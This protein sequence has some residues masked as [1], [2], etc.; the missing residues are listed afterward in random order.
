[1]AD[2]KAVITILGEDKASGPIGKANKSLGELDKTAT[3][4]GKALG[5]VQTA[6]LGVAGVAAGAVVA[7]FGASVKA[8]ADFESQISALKAVTGASAEDA[9]QLSDLAL[10]LG[11]DTAFS[12]S[13]AAAGL[14]ELAKGGVDV[15]DIMGGAA[16]ASL[17]LAA[18]GGIEVAEA[19][20]LAANAMALFNIQ[21]SEMGAVVDSIAGF[22]NATTGSVNDF[23]LAL[24]AVGAVADLS[25]QDFD[26]TATAIA[27]MGKA[28]IL[29]SDAGTSLKGVLLN[30]IPTTNAAQQAMVELGLAN[31]ETRSTFVDS[32]GNFKDLRDIAEELNRATKDLTES[33][34][35]LAL[36]VIFGSDA[37]RAAAILA[38]AGAEGFDAM[39]ES[40]SKVSAE[41]VAAERLNNVNGSMQAMQGSLETL[42]IT[43]G[44]EFLPMLK[45]L[46]D[47][48]TKLAN[49]QLIPFIQEHGP[50]W[51]ATVK[52]MGN[53][54][55]RFIDDP[56][57]GL[58]ETLPETTRLL[59]AMG[60]SGMGPLLTKTGELIVGL[61]KL[62][63]SD[64][65]GTIHLGN[66]FLNLLGPIG[67]AI[68][69]LEGASKSVNDVTAALSRFG[70]IANETFTAAQLIGSQMVEGVAAG[71]AGAVGKVADQARNMV[72]TAM[73]AAR[74]KAEAKSPSEWFARDVGEPIAEGTAL[75][76]E[77]GTWFVRAAATE[78]VEEA[79]DAATEPAAAKKLSTFWQQVATYAEGQAIASAFPKMRDIGL[80]MAEHAAKGVV[81]GAVPTMRDL[82]LGM[83]EHSA[84]GIVAGTP[85]VVEAATA[86]GQQAGQAAA[87]AF[88]QMAGGVGLD[89]KG[90][91]G[92]GQTGTAASPT[93]G[94]WKGGGLGTIG[95][96]WNANGTLKMQEG[97]IVTRPTIALVGE[98]GPEAVI[99][100]NRQPMEN[101]V[102]IEVAGK[103]IAH[104]VLDT[105]TG[106]VRTAAALGVGPA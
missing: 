95:S 96:I 30:L 75:G 90:G 19:A 28:G 54:V 64:E 38:D 35:S 74:E 98:A 101:H 11:K 71:I 10:Q 77:R 50:Q 100:L 40:M 89:W 79:I 1:M 103:E 7:G 60:E 53:E 76:I 31:D 14:T 16:K 82:G 36:E 33:E 67:I 59:N 23:S 63:G 29:G 18:A 92:P 68:S 57:H 93:S 37:I 6:M 51:A 85:A 3:T 84:K 45:E 15:A 81:A 94:M 91:P 5:G 72:T 21:G 70:T 66:Q 17:D 105:L 52:D 61:A 80:G 102:H 12:A 78:M 86:M 46:I 99:P 41:A 20:A 58:G 2:L 49:E 25:G 106:Q 26:Q 104:V 24:K 32:E 97:G 55:R 8:A 48:F 65:G 39:A 83:A 43:L 42:G 56:L 22:A 4:S 62:G 69:A 88:G 47:S 87:V 34:K 27:L 73:N 44:L 9:K 13:E